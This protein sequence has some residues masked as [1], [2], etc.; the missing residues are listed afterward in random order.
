V[1]AIWETIRN[2]DGL[3]GIS[4]SGGEPFEQ[5][6]ACAMLAEL[7]QAAGLSVLVYTGKTLEALRLPE[8]RRLLAAVDIL[9]AGPFVASKLVTGEPL[10]GSANQ[11]IHFLTRRYSEADL[12]DLPVSEVLI[13]PDGT[14]V[15]M[16]FPEPRMQD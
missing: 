4:I 14:I 6:T 11:T 8:H 7:A 5:A 2:I 10:L 16:G 12:L 13:R 9:V 3:E 15:Y 1:E